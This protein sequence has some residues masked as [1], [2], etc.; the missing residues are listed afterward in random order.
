MLLY[1]IDKFHKVFCKCLIRLR[2]GKDK[3]YSYQIKIMKFITPQINRHSKIINP[4]KE[5]YSDLKTKKLRASA[6][7]EGA[8]VIPLFIYAVMTIM[9]VIQIVAIRSHV[10]EALYNTLKKCEGYGY[11]YESYVNGN[12]SNIEVSDFD[13]EGLLN[14]AA[15]LKNGMIAE[16]I[17][18][19]FINELGKDYAKNNNVV[20]ESA[21][22][23]FIST[24][25]LK[26]NSVIDIKLSYYLKNP[27]DIF[28]A[29]KIK[30][31][32]RKR[33]N[34][35]LGEDKDDFCKNEENDDEYVYITL[36][37]EV[38]HTNSSCT[39]LLRYIKELDINDISQIRNTSGAKYYKCQVCKNMITEGKVYYTEYGT[40]YHMSKLCTEL[41]RDVQKVTKESVK[42]R[43]KC[44]KC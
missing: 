38:Y 15:N 27:F 2:K 42:N 24:K 20:G 25:I 10:N 6:T 32:D 37:G 26:G 18:R 3:T 40:R 12:Y 17:R 14:N 29:S 19:M 7:L 35:W 31:T 1:G 4:N 5:A 9:Y 13:K 33:V 39:Y 23:I 22:F 28:G 11:V 44:E 21:G 43:K 36:N 41:T 8:L 30:M 34:V 16:T